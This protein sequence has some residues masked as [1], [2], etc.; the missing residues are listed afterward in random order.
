M[1]K[2]LVGQLLLVFVA[3]Q[4]IGLYVGYSLIQE[5]VKVTLVTENPEDIENSIGLFAYILVFT[6]VLLVVLKFY[7]GWLLFKALESIV[8][9]GTGWIVFSAFFG[10]VIGLVL[11]L[12]LVALRITFKEKV[13]LRNV[14]SVTAAS[15]AGAAIGLGLGVIPVIVFL[16]LLALYDFIAVFYTK[17]MVTLAK[18]IKDKNLSFTF[19]LPTKEH[20]FELG[21]GDMVMPLVFAVSVLNSS[22]KQFSFVFPVSFVAPAAVL[23]GSIIGLLLTINYSS[24]HVGKPLPALP[25]QAILM[26]LML[27]LSWSTGFFKF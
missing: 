6:V 7:K 19:A 10:E 11:A 3:T 18:G 2:K 26:V 25:P 24:K 16:A 1:N 21:T 8:I 4:L 20:T 13:W 22:L 9:F 17:H 15:G 27:A 12:L 14:S 5:E 23:T